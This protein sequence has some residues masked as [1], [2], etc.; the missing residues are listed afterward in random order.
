MELFQTQQHWVSLTAY[1][2]ELRDKQQKHIYQPVLAALQCRSKHNNRE[3]FVLGDLVELP[4]IKSAGWAMYMGR[5]VANN[6]SNLIFNGIFVEPFPDL[7]AIPYGMVIVGG[8]NEIISELAGEVE[9]DNE[10]YKQE[11]EDYCIGKI[12]ATIDM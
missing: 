8:N 6:L 10:H 7:N 9:V 12:R 1:L 3:F 11:Y 5:Q 2:R 4:I